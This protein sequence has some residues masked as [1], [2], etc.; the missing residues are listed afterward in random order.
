MSATNST[1][2][3]EL[4]VFL[5][6]DKPA[7]LVDWNGA[8]ASIDAAI[9]EAKQT[10]DSAGTSASGV[11]SDLA[12]LSGTVTTQGETISTISS[13][14]TTA[15]GN[16]NTINSLIGNGT[17]TTTDQTLIGAINELNAGKAE[18]SDVTTAVNSLDSRIDDLEKN[19]FASGVQLDTY[20]SDNRYVAPSDGYVYITPTGSNLV[21]VALRGPDHQNAFT[22]RS[23]GEGNYSLT[24]VKK[25]CEIYR[26]AGSDHVFFIALVSGS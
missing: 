24:F 16:I 9:Y 6:S 10:A 1:T 13:T 19:N 25:G 3:Y 22:I 7:W 11:A 15:V 4:P 8:M 2:H 20:T 14:L 21:T 26:A 18:S 23:T 12:T 5:G 17:P